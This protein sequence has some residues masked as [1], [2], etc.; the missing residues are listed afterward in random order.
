MKIAAL[1]KPNGK[2]TTNARVKKSNSRPSGILL[3]F[4]IRYNAVIPPITRPKSE[5]PPLGE[6]KSKK[7]LSPPVG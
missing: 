6:K 3:Y 2:A 1:T 5:K 7:K 4:P